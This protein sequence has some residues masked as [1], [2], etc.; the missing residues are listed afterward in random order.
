MPQ[1][2]NEVCSSD[3][4]RGAM[5]NPLDRNQEPGSKGALPL[6]PLLPQE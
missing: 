3:S 1:N 4:M 2:A 6:H 5:G